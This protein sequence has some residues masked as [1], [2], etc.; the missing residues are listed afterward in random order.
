M[1]FGYL[2]DIGHNLID[3]STTCTRMHRSFGCGAPLK[4]L[5]GFILFKNLL[6]LSSLSF[7]FVQPLVSR[8][9]FHV[10][11]TWGRVGFPLVK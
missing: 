5:R 3:S 6:L 8:F 2:G 10:I 4:T 11:S 7:F 9:P 1:P